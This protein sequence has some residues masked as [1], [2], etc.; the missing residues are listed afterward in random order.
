MLQQA[1]QRFGPR[2]A[3]YTPV[4]FEFVDNPVP[5]IWFLGNKGI[6]VRLPL[7][8]AN[9]TV[10]ACYQLAHECIHMLSPTGGSHA[11]NLEEGLATVFSEEYV[12]SALGIPFHP[13]DAKYE[14]AAADVR[15]L[16]AD[17]TDVIRKI[18]QIQPHFRNITV[19]NIRQVIPTC[20]EELSN[21][22][23]SPF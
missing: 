2:D 3:T 19:E 11:N 1:E 8:C 7:A 4:G 10:R 15:T 23:L 12:L 13:G 21:R 9:D 14:A 22:L 17:D 5:Y 20:S 6:I 16:L 18:R